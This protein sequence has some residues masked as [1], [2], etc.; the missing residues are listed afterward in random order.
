[1]S[2]IDKIKTRY[3]LRKKHSADNKYS[4]LLPYVVHSAAESNIVLSTILSKYLRKNIKETTVLEVGCGSGSNLLRLLSFG[5]KP[6]NLAGNDLLS[7]RIE[8]AKNRLPSNIE[9]T[10]GDACELSTERKYD[11]VYQSTV[12]TSILDDKVKQRLAD[13]MWS[14]LEPSG[15][16]LWYD[17]TFNNPKNKDVKGVPLRE[18]RSLFPQGKIVVYHKLTM[19]PPLGRLLLNKYHL[20]FLFNVLNHFSFLKTHVFCVIRK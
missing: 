4:M 1:M 8:I 15:F 19:A 6:E 5:F 10:L 11:I 18:I 9:I 12:F 13:K 17:F 20:V 14:Q 3:D 16:I 7:E 2:E